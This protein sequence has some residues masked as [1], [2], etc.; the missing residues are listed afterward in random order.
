ML[1]GHEK[2]CFLHLPTPIEY[3]PNISKDL[4][5]ELYIKRDDL[6]PLAM[7]GNKLRKLEYFLKDAKDKGATLLLT[8]GGIQTNHGRLTLAVAISTAAI[9]AAI[10]L[11]FLSVL[12]TPECDW[13]SLSSLT[14]LFVSL[15]RRLPRP[16]TNERT[17]ITIII[18]ISKRTNAA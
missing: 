18:P 5:I 11:G 7:G 17:I 16:T 1:L 14:Y 10:F 4:G 12:L 6:T 13:V 2:E 8:T 15:I 9:I 3:L